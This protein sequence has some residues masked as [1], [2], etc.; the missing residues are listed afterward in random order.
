LKILFVD[1]GFPSYA[2]RYAYDI[3]HTLTVDFNYEVQQVSPFQLTPKGIDD[4]RP[5]VLLVVHGTNTSLETVRYARRHRISTVLWLVEDPYEIDTHRGQMVAA[6]DYVFTNETIALKEYA[7]AQVFHLPWCC[8]PQVHQRMA[9]PVNY[10]SDVCFVGMGFRN[11]V[12]IL[13]AIVPFLRQLKVTLIGDWASWGE[14]LHPELKKMVIPV[15]ND[16]FEVVRHF[17]GAKINLNIHRDPVDPQGGNRRGVPAVSPNDRTFILAGCGCFQMV[18]QTRPEVFNC[19]S[20]GQEIEAFSDPDDL[21]RQIKYY[22][23]HPESR[24]KIGL[25]AQKR[26]YAEHTYQQRLESMFRIIRKT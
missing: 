19:F 13:N 17:N 9:V 15:I 20:K 26:A 11:R 22:L 10:Q 14:A 21:A 25:Q 18:D 4:F 12:R 3:F 23:D 8:N 7:G 1:P 6:Y 24:E 16:F 5:D 2:M